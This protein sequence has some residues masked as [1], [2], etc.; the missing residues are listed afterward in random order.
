MTKKRSKSSQRWMKEHFDDEYVRKAQQMGYRSRAVFKLEEIQDK[1]KLIQPGMVVV[2]LGAAP[3]GWSQYTQK[4]VGA[5]GAVY[6]LDILP[7]EPIDDVEFIQGDFRE[8]AVFDELLSKI[9]GRSVDLVISDMA[10]NITGQSAVDQPRSMYLCELALD[11]S[12]QLLPSGGD[13]LLKAFQGKGYCELEKDI[14]AAFKK[15]IVRKP[16][17]S[18]A[19][20]REVYILARGYNM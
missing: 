14:K 12:Q 1:D 2:D 19:R 10:P 15:V 5:K 8:Q 16:K 3:G 13:L 18:R 4:I 20:S 6:A 11:L 7:I 9:Q 17:A